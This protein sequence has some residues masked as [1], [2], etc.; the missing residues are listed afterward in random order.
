MP[1]IVPTYQ[2]KGVQRLQQTISRR[3]MNIHGKQQSDVVGVVVGYDAYYAIYVHENLQAYHANG[4]AKFLVRA[5]AAKKGEGLKRVA[6]QLKKGRSIGQALY[7]FGEMVRIESQKRVPV[8]TG[9]LR[10]SAKTQ[11]LRVVSKKP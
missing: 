9:A 1:P 5:L 7:A 4:E 10:A 3:L 2:M 8:K 6:E 11:L